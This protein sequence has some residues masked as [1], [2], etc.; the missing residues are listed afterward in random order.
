MYFFSFLLSYLYFGELFSK[1]YQVLSIVWITPCRAVFTQQF[2]K[3]SAGLHQLT[4]QETAY[5][6]IIFCLLW[7]LF[8]TASLE[9]FL[10][11]P[12]LGKALL[13]RRNEY[14]FS[15]RLIKKILT[16]RRPIASWQIY[17]PIIVPVPSGPG[18]MCSIFTQ[19]HHHTY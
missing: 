6:P 7:I 16:D 1:E 2:L 13:P 3:N 8:T 14:V 17:C 4:I 11:K 15:P 9:K 5:K 10:L 18:H 12:I 19:S